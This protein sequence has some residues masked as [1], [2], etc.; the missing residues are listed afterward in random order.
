MTEFGLSFQV[1]KASRRV[2]GLDF[3]AESHA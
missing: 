3:G 2:E 1:E